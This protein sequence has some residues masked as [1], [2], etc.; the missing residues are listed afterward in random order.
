LEF[1]KHRSESCRQYRRELCSRTL[2]SGHSGAFLVSAAMIALERFGACCC[3][4]ELA[5]KA[6]AKSNSIIYSG[7]NKNH[8]YI[9]GS[10]KL[11]RRVG[12]P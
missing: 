3:S 7:E 9:Y 1:A 4:R 11:I 10:D 2:A 8:S 6:I 12:R 5:E